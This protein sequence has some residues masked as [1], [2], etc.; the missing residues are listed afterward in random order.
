VNYFTKKNPSGKS[1]FSC[2]VVGLSLEVEQIVGLLFVEERKLKVCVTSDIALFVQPL[3]PD[4]REKCLPLFSE[5]L[6]YC[7]TL[8]SNAIRMCG[9]FEMHSL[10]QIHLYCQERKIKYCLV[11]RED[12]E[13]KGE[14]ITKILTFEKDKPVERR[15]PTSVKEVLEVVRSLLNSE[16][17]PLS[18]EP[19]ISNEKVKSERV[20]S[21]RESIDH[22]CPTSFTSVLNIQFMPLENKVATHIKKKYETVIASL[23]D[24]SF[25]SSTLIHVLAVEVPFKI[26]K[27][28]VFEVDLEDDPTKL[29]RSLDSALSA[30]NERYPRYKK[31]MS[32]I[33]DEIYA[34]KINKKAP[35]IT[36]FTWLENKFVTFT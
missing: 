31:Y 12:H 17:Q 32:S 15:C 34:L 6:T 9:P 35:S 21:Q 30:L 16:I 23:F 4:D 24:H 20:T 1:T 26:I 27:A 8:R 19:T 25:N 28:V 2:G 11:L 3:D 29:R 22:C 33:L 10:D 5:A 7:R 13:K 18:S 36:L 14:I